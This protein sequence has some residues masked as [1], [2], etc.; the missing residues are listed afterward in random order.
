MYSVISWESP[1]ALTE[2]LK[3]NQVMKVDGKI[4]YMYKRVQYIGKELSTHGIATV[5]LLLLFYYIAS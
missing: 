5:I 3:T 1:E 4:L 2:V